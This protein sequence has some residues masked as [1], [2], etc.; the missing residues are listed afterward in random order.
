MINRTKPRAAGAWSVGSP[1]EAETEHGFDH[2][3]EDKLREIYRADEPLPDD[4]DRLLRLIGD[5]D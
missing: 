3:L 5:R 4:M 2:W 1:L